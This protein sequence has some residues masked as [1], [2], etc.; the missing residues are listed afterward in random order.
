MDFTDECD[1]QSQKGWWC[2]QSVELGERP[3]FSLDIHLEN[4]KMMF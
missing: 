2:R 3:N 4:D 1:S